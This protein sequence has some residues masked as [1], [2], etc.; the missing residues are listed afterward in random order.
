MVQRIDANTEDIVDNVEGAQR[1]L[2]K[3]WSRVSGN[4]W[5]VAK[6]FGVLMVR[7]QTQ[8]EKSPPPT[9][10]SYSIHPSIHPP[11]HKPEE[12]KKN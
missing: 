3:Y 4:R 10:I 2:M 12:K 7:G 9:L 8:T 5:L 11:N 1:E 6:M